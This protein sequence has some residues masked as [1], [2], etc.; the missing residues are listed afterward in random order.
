VRSVVAVVAWQERALVA[1]GVGAAVLLLLLQ[2][3]EIQKLRGDVAHY[4]SDYREAEI[5]RFEWQ[6]SALE[7]QERC[8]EPTVRLWD[9]DCD[10]IVMGKTGEGR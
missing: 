8:S 3:G 6:K 1:L 7:W 9:C 4:R 5:R 2:N 10:E